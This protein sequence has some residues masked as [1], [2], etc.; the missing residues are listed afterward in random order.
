[1][2]MALLHQAA[3]QHQDV[4]M[5]Y[6]DAARVATSGWCRRSRCTAA[7]HGVGCGTGADSRVRGAPGDVGGGGPTGMMDR[8]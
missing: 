5:G 1:M 7:T 3:V 2:A 4:L 8:G 6:V